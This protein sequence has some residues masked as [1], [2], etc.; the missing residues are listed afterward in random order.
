M[1]N[2]CDLGWTKF[3]FRMSDAS[4]SGSS[5]NSGDESLS[6]N[7][8]DRTFKFFRE[9]DK[10]LSVNPRQKIKNAG[11]SPSVFRGKNPEMALGDGPKNSRIRVH[12]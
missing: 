5:L 1:Y 4:D 7:D 10:P 3:I 6:D 9:F 2:Y 12:G 8:Q 11:P